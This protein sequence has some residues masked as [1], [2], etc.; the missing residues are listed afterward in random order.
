MMLMFE[1]F[2]RPILKVVDDKI[3]GKIETVYSKRFK[4]KLRY[5]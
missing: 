1:T 4:R 3:A 2:K 5:R